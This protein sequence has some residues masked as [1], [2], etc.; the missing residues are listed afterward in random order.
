MSD[1]FSH[2]AIHQEKQTAHL[3]HFLS[4][5]IH[6]RSTTRVQAYPFVISLF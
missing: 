3:T 6:S 5:I 4:G 2:S 1:M